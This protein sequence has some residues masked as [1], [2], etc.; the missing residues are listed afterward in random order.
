MPCGGQG[1]PQEFVNFHWQHDPLIR[2]QI[3]TWLASS[4]LL[5]F[6]Y[7]GWIKWVAGG[8]GD[9]CPL[10]SHIMMLGDQRMVPMGLNWPKRWTISCGTEEGHCRRLEG[11]SLLL[12]NCWPTLRRWF[13]GCHLHLRQPQAVLSTH[14]AQLHTESALEAH[15]INYIMYKPIYITYIPICMEGRLVR[16][17]LTSTAVNN[18]LSETGS[19]ANLIVA[20]WTT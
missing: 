15:N 6:R 3:Q 20:G 2:K 1:Q 16:H 19:Y 17:P 18:L 13:H 5:M 4:F 9:R 14:K 10:L 11:V 7:N 12:I 8:L